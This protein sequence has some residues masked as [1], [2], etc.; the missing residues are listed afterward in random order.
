MTA[1]ITAF[2]PIPSLTALPLVLA[3]LL[4]GSTAIARPFFI[5]EDIVGVWNNRVVVAAAYRAKDPDK[6]LVGFNNAPEYPGARAA[7]SSSDDGNLN[8]LK[9]DLIS[10]PI[11]YTTDLELRYKKR[12]GFYGKARSWY[13]YAGETRDVPHG[14][15]TNGYL[16]D[17]KLDDSDYYKYNKFSGFRVADLYVFG[18]WDI[19]ASRLTGRLGQQSINWGESLLY[20]GINA[21]NPINF[22]A[23]G[24]P[25]VRQDDALVPVNRIYTNLITRN[26]VSLEAFYALDWEES[27]I[28]P[29]GTVASAA[30]NVTDPGC[31][32][33][34]SAVPLTDQQQLE[35]APLSENPYIVPRVSSGK[36]GS[37]GQYGLST[38]YYVEALD[39][40]FG[41]YYE[42]A[43]ARFSV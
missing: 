29:C 40:E 15:A 41:L 18:N 14:S 36:P 17:S 9:G 23:L 11:I 19:G 10:A 20:T 42:A 16:P 4:H 25:G 13:D 26:G 32:F 21:F 37:G 24:R 6:Q 22:S 12:Y 43:K 30:D 27:H 28:G 7:V 1:R 5:N 31:N 39:T 33:G 2:F 3:G 8:Y 38:R 35:L 34:T